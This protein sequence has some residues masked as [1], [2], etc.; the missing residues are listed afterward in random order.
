M[1]GVF[2]MV[3]S[4]K[5]RRFGEAVKAKRNRLGLDQIQ[6]GLEIWGAQGVSPTAAQTRVSRIERGDYWP[7]R[8]DVIKIIDHLN[9]W[10]EAFGAAPEGFI[11]IDP[12]WE[13]YVP[14]LR[15]IVDM[16]SGYARDGK[17]ILFYDMLNHLCEV[18]RVEMDKVAN[19]DP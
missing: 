11:V 13:R 6:L 9:L 5:R 7:K 10:E 19:D 2:L 17:T 3:D 18:A 12:A 1:E 4:T 8:E 14:N 16:L 15:H